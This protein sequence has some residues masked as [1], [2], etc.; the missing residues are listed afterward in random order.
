M[1][2]PHT[3]GLVLTV[4]SRLARWRLLE[5]NRKQEEAGKK[6]WPTPIILPLKSWLKQAWVQSWPERFVLTNLQSLKLWEEII[7]RD[8][9]YRVLD[10]LHLNGLAQQAAE[11]F[12]LIQEYCLPV[13]TEAF[14]WTEE[15][16][17]F[18]RWMRQ[19]EKQLKERQALDAATLPDAVREAMD[20]G[21]IPFPR[22]LVLAGFEEVTPQ[23]QSCLD[24][25]KRKG[26]RTAFDPDLPGHHPPSLKDLAT[27]KNI[28]VRPFDGRKEEAIQCARWVRHWHQPGKRFGIVATD[29][30][31][32]RSI[33]QRELSAEL[34]PD[35]I[36]PWVTKDPLFNLSLG[37][38]LAEEPLVNSALLLLSIQHAAVPLSIFSAVIKSPYLDA[39]QRE[40]VH[41]HELD[42]ALRKNNTV[43]VYLQQAEKLIGEEKS[44]R[45]FSLI[46]RWTEWTSVR[47]NL[48]PSDWGKRYSVFLRGLGWPGGG[49]TLTSREHQVYQAWKECLDA[50]A[51]LDGIIGRLPRRQAAV[52]LGRIAEEQPFQ[53]KTREQPIQVVG[54]LESSGMTFDHLWVMGCHSE[55]LPAMPSPNPFLSVDFRKKHNLP[56]SSAQ[57]ELEFAENSLRRLISSSNNILFSYPIWDRKTDLKMSPLLAPLQNAGKEPGMGEETPASH[58]VKDGFPPFLHLETLEESV[59]IP[60]TEIERR[61]FKQTGLAGG[62]T[63]L[64]D[65]AECPFRAFSIH[66]LHTK[67]TDLPELDFDSQERGILVHKALQKFWEK[68]KTMKALQQLE[69]SNQLNKTVREA[70]DSAIRNFSNKLSWQNRFAQLEHE[71][72]VRLMEEWLEMELRRSDFEV[73]HAEKDEIVTI[74]GIELKLRIDRIDRMDRGKT[75]VIDYKTGNNTA[76]NSPKTWFGD[77]VQEPQLPLYA[78]HIRPDAVAFGQVKKGKV[79]F[80]TVADPQSAFKGLNPKSFE[81]DSGCTTWPELIDYWRNKLTGL[82]DQFLEGMTGVDPVKDETTCRNCGHQ[83]FCRVRELRAFFPDEEEEE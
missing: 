9:Q 3:A 73:L 38:P 45:L 55:A 78:L 57:R 46:H 63:A 21:D 76:K 51:S 62:Y 34:S 11:A 6:V 17:A 59:R 22:E 66:R 56:R 49:R 20:R 4:N 37:G 28:Q 61:T 47:E 65:Q 74:S 23:L 48:L 64:R 14:A 32:Y 27:G 29:L 19:Y 35:S 52:A 75:L 1:V 12:S 8:P 43:T 70:V 44:P 80:K 2:P 58:R 71:R 25:L 81:K 7:R 26:T 10:L 83:T 67:K 39:G 31:E 68:T 50:F 69:S 41:A 30:R 18:H 72:I 5:Y 79:M 40:P 77:R 36:F 42:L 15:S 60:A 16:W 82:A 33:L 13:E 24:F 53:E 54:L